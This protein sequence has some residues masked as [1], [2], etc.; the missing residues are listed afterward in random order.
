MLIWC[1]FAF[2]DCSV[3][4]FYTGKDDRII[5][6]NE[7]KNIWNKV[8]LMDWEVKQFYRCFLERTLSLLD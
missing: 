1:L 6:F 4:N 3:L 5:W 8:T 2:D 7:I